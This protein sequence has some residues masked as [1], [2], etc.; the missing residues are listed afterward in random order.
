[1]RQT[2][3]HIITLWIKDDHGVVMA[4]V[5]PLN[6]KIDLGVVLAVL[7]LDLEVGIVAPFGSDAVAAVVKDNGGQLVPGIAFDDSGSPGWLGH[8]CLILP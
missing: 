3:D 1:V 5:Q 8:D 6:E 2:H 4:M 7:G